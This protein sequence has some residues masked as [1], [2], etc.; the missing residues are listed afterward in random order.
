[1]DP[2]TKYVVPTK[3]LFKWEGKTKSGQ[4]MKAEVLLEV[5]KEN[6]MCRFELLAHI[7]G[8]FRFPFSSLF[9]FPF[10]FCFFPFLFFFVFFLF[11]LSFLLTLLL[12]PR[13]IVEKLIAKP[14]FYQYYEMAEG[15]ITIGDVTKT[16][17]GRCMHEYHFIY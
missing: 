11:F 3:V 1:M 8:V 15:T 13:M 4:D 16:V 14:V 17:S 2:E 6:L 5:K 9:P 12:S 7:P 10:F